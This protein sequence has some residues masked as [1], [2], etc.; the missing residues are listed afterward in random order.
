MT[1]SNSD[2]HLSQEINLRTGDT[3]FAERVRLNQQLTADNPFAHLNINV[4]FS[5]RSSQTLC[6]EHGCHDEEWTYFVTQDVDTFEQAVAH[7]SYV[8][9]YE[10]SLIPGECAKTKTVFARQ[11]L[12]R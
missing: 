9:S 5:R 6:D 8:I 10:R 1:T 2:Q 3:E 12:S 11:R 7:C 4:L